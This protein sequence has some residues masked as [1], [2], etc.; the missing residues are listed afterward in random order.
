VRNIPHTQ[1]IST[2]ISRPEPP[3]PTAFESLRGL[4]A[5]W[6]VLG[7]VLGRTFT[8]EELRSFHLQIFY[9]PV[10]AVDVFIILSGFVIFYQLDTRRISYRSFILQRFLRLWPLYIVILVISA[11]FLNQSITLLEGFRW[12]TSAITNALIEGPGTIENFWSYFAVSLF[13]LQ[14]LIPESSLPHAPYALVGQGWSLSLEWQ[15]YL[16][17]PIFFVLVARRNWLA[18]FIITACFVVLRGMTYENIAFLPNQFGYFLMGILSYFIYKHA[19]RI[20]ISDCQLGDLLLLAIAAIAYFL[21]S[22]PWSLTAWMITLGTVVF[23]KWRMQGYITGFVGSVLRV[24]FLRWLGAISYSIYLTH[25]LIFRMFAGIVLHLDP[26]ISKVGFFA[27]LLPATICGTLVISA[28]TRRWI[29]E[30]GIA[31]GKCLS[32]RSLEAC[33]AR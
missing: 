33:P 16:L 19:D 12:R 28:V 17:S 27:I 14:G 29:E 21:L 3:R 25:I 6:V 7:H 4:L 8:E 10:L 30:P 32:N 20:R 2:I 1:A 22:N 13:L 24:P 31:L 18:L 23:E 11:L 26:E 5:L 15:F 9:Q